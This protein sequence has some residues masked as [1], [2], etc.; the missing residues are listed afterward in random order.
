MH[1]TRCS[2]AL[3]ALKV[4]SSYLVSHLL[5]FNLNSMGKIK[6]INHVIEDMLRHHDKVMQDDWD[7]FLTMV[8]FAYNKF[9]KK[10]M[11]NT[12]QKPRSTSHYTNKWDQQISSVCCKDFLLST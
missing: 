9:W 10:F 3:M 2:K 11:Q 8:E 12:S 5:A 6:Y 7:E 4:T 1:L